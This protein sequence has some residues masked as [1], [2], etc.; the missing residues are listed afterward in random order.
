MRRT[1]TDIR[2]RCEC[3]IPFFL[4]LGRAPWARSRRTHPADAALSPHAILQPRA[5]SASALTA[6]LTYLLSS[7]CTL[8]RYMSCTGL[9][10]LDRVNLP[11]G[12]SISVFSIAAT[13]A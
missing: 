4:I 7:P 10:A 5:G 11:R 12:L 1:E 8:R 9:C 13:I 6:T 3:E 2:L